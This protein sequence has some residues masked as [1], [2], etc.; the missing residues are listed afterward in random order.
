[1]SRYSLSPQA[2]TYLA[3]IWFYIAADSVNAADRWID[4]LYDAFGALAQN[5]DMGRTRK[6]FTDLAILFWPVGMYLILY[7]AL[8]EELEIIAVTQD[9]RDLPSFLR[10][11]Q[12]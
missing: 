10:Q 12:T 5:P 7:R 3:E 2:Q 1:M 8:P 11:R 6:D 9:N 4:K